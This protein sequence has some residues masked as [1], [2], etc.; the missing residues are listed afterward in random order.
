MEDESSHPC[1]ECKVPREL[2]LHTDKL[3]P[4][5]EIGDLIGLMRKNWTMQQFWNS[6]NSNSS[7]SSNSGQSTV[8]TMSVFDYQ[9]LNSIVS[10]FISK[11]HG[12]HTPMQLLIPCPLLLYFK[13]IHAINLFK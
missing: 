2:L 6:S 11:F 5:L 9:P 12:P 13:I 8:N 3:M 10:S 1:V 4:P 7:N